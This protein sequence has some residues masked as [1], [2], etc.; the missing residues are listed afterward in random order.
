M[1][2]MRLNFNMDESLVLQI[3]EYAK[4]MHINRSAAIAVL[5]SQSLQGLKVGDALAELST[6]FKQAQAAGLLDGAKNGN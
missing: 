3:D 4:Q 1:A 2:L 6:Q 5:V